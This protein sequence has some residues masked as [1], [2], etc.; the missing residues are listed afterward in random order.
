MYTILDTETASLQGGVVELALLHI[1]TELN[2]LGEFHTKVNPERPIEPGAFAVHGISDADVADAPTLAQIPE[3]SLVTHA[4]A[5]NCLT[6]DHE[7]LT[8]G[9]W[10]RL[11]AL[12]GHYVTAATWKTDGTMQWE[13]CRVVRQEHS[14][15][16][17]GYSSQYHCGVYT[18]EHRIV[19]TS[20]RSLLKQGSPVWKVCSAGD[21]SRL[22]PN[23][24]AIPA[25]GLLDG[26]GCGLSESSVRLIEAIRADGHIGVN[27]SGSIYIRLNLSKQRKMCR[28]RGLLQGSGIPYSELPRRG[29]PDVTVFSLLKHP[30]RDWIADFLGAG[31]SKSYGAKLFNLSLQ[32]RMWLLDEIGYWDAS[33]HSGPLKGELQKNTRTAVTTSKRDE[34]VWLQILSVISGKSAKLLAERPNNRG[35]SKDDGVLSEVSLR[36]RNY[37]KTLYKPKVVEAGVVPVFCLT[38]E[39]GFFMVRRDGAVWVTGNCPF[40]SRMLKGH[41]NAEASLCTLSLSR[42]YLKGT[43]NHKLENLKHELGLPDR[44]SHSALGDVYTTLDLL[45]HLLPLTGVPLDTLF[46]RAAQPKLIHRMT[47][48]KHRG[49]LI[50]HVPADY[51]SWLLGQENLDKD[52]RYT[53]ERLK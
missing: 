35:F 43:A 46:K 44:K 22:S 17:L 5:H 26:P 52:L 51:R 19:Y 14:G 24:V 7:V 25:A 30:V 28:L 45:R 48:G 21:Y 29:R 31:L 42:Q 1:D 20:T 37:V 15:P 34:A 6:G 50:S 3:L 2:V 12:T 36:A 39:A 38:T 23:S 27:S 33:S 10:V 53:L 13:T 8:K 16:M 49:L 40:D 32:E 11:D 4:I 18:P 47:F 9:G 41:L